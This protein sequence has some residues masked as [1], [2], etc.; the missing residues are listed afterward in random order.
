[1]GEAVVE[2]SKDNK[3]ESEM[4]E[5]CALHKTDAELGIELGNKSFCYAY[6]QKEFKSLREAMIKEVFRDLTS[7]WG[8]NFVVYPLS[9]CDDIQLM[10]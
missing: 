9:P 2:E 10:L 1:M 7:K 4:D 3:G 5:D 6:Y 8:R